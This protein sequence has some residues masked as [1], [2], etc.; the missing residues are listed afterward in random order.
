MK[1]KESTKE[2]FI[3]ARKER[4]KIF[5]TY[6]SGKYSLFFTKLC[7]PI[8]YVRPINEFEHDYFYFWDEQADVGDRLFGLPLEDISYLELSD[9]NY[10]PNDYIITN[11]SEV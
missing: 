9:E 1:E 10:N 8:Q 6:F 11:T 2:A 3:K 7:V 5:L 4:K